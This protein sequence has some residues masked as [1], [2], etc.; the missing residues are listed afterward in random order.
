MAVNDVDKLGYTVTYESESH[1]KV[2][3]QMWG[4]VWP[5]VVPYCMLNVLIT[6]II[7]W[8]N[9][10]EDINLAISEKG[11]SFMGFLVAFLVVS[12][13]NLAIGR[14]NESRGCL[15]VM[16]RE[17][18]ELVQNMVA[19]SQYNTDDKAKEWRNETAYQTCLLLRVA[20]GVIDYPEYFVNVWELDELDDFERASMKKYIYL[21]TGSGPNALRWSHG[22]RTEYEE[23]MRVPIRLSYLLRKQI[24]KMRKMLAEPFTPPQEMKLMGSVDSFMGGYFGMRKF[25]TTPFPFPLVQMARTFLYFYV[26]TVSFVLLKDDSSALT[27]C[28]T[29]FILTFGFM[30]LEYVSIELDNPFGED[31]NDFDNLGM[32]CT[33][34]EDTYL[35][36]L[37]IDG[38][39]WTDRLHRRLNPIRN[40]GVD[41]AVESTPLL[42]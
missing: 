5:K 6:L 38:P 7:E 36:I 19:L 24:R 40:T 27:H 21:D 41:T 29:I 13:V 3:T 18:R 32:A 25:M 14:Y 33:A 42:V 15:G 16:Y 31:D 34:F 35:T 37:E 23:N 8:L 30:G 12:R 10:K 11:H 20:M 2:I 17:S 9:G 39:E 4:S 22:Q 26:F 28:I 1:W